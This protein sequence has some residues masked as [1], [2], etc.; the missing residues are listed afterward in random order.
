MLHKSKRPVEAYFLKRASAP[1]DLFNSFDVKYEKHYNCK[2]SLHFRGMVDTLRLQ[3]NSTGDAR[4]WLW[5]PDFERVFSKF[6]SLWSICS[7]KTNLI[8]DEENFYFS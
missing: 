2:Y 3:S 6:S 8:F 7:S 5:F 4:L 1:T